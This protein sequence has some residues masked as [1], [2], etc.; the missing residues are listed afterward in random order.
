MAITEQEVHVVCFQIL[1]EG[2]M[3]TFKTIRS[4]LGERGSN[5]TINKYRDTW[6]RRLDDGFDNPA[7]SDV[8]SD[9]KTPIQ[10]MW[11]TALTIAQEMTRDEKSEL[12]SRVRSLNLEINHKNQNIDEYKSKISEINVKNENLSL[13]NQNLL[14]RIKTLEDDLEKLTS[15][16]AVLIK[17]T[18]KTKDE[19][20]DLKDETN[21]LKQDLKEIR[22]ELSDQKSFTQ[23]LMKKT[24]SALECFSDKNDKS[25]GRAH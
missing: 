18:N 1:R 25:E 10:T 7:L 14:F 5:T 12:E 19:N 21:E 6:L 20:V 3:P 15:D 13:S 16:N 24:A 2:Q 4:K 22:L 23:E 8:P 9:L 17:V 11:S